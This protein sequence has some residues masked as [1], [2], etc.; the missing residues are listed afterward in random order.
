MEVTPNTLMMAVLNS[1]LNRGVPK[2]SKAPLKYPQ[3]NPKIPNS[4]KLH[5]KSR[6]PKIPKIFKIELNP[7]TLK[8]KSIHPPQQFVGVDKLKF[9][10]AHKEPNAWSRILLGSIL[11]Q[12]PASKDVVRV[13]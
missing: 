13:L 7:S 6:N 11:K 1:D 3:K 5:K 10:S 2:Y 9:T 8:A 12:S 4:R